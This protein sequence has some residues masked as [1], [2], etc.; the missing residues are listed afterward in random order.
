MDA[1]ILPLRAL[2]ARFKTVRHESFSTSAGIS[3]ESLLPMRFRMRREGSTV[4]QAR[5]S[6]TMSFQSA[7]TR[8]VRV[9][10]PQIAAGA[11]N[12]LKDWVF[13]LPVEVDVADAA[14]GGVATDAVP[15]ETAVGAHPRVEEV[16][17]LVQGS[18]FGWGLIQAISRI[19]D[20]NY[21]RSTLRTFTE[22]PIDV[23]I[24]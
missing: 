19:L 22:K 24:P 5:I 6:S 2:S 7:T 20:S 21:S 18:I 13:G 17:I 9:S 10:T 14:G 23:K 3:P 8:V 4:T 12:F 11:T 1:G 16:K 15:V